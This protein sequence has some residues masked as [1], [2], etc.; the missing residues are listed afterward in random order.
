M[1]ATVELEP[2]EPRPVTAR[3]EHALRRFAD[4]TDLV[5][6]RASADH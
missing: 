3:S 2:V 1:T 5:H 6:E 4:L